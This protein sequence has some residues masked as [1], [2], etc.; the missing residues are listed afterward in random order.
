MGSTAPTNESISAPRKTKY[1]ILVHTAKRPNLCNPIC[2]LRKRSRLIKKNDIY[3]PCHL[4]RKTPLH[5]KTIFCRH[6]RGDR[7]N[8]RNREPE[9]VRTCDDKHGDKARKGEAGT[10]ITCKGK[11]PVCE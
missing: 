7:G 8:E 6:G 10:S 11:E 1:F 4:K 2:P 5:E 3:L 9:C